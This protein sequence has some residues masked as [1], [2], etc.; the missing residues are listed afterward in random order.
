MTIVT[1]S[2]RET[3][4]QGARMAA[5]A[6]PGDVYA[7]EGELGAGKT[8]FVR[9]FVG[10]LSSGAAVKSPSFSLLDSYSTPA[11]SVHHFDF[12]RLSDPSELTEIGFDDCAGSDSVCLIEWGTLFPDVLPE[13]SYILT[14][15]DLGE[16]RREI[17]LPDGLIDRK[18]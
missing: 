11:F 4:R 7:L 16:N 5:L 13:R 10:A 6:R 1:N 3:R 12:Y 18:E 17:G 8:E 9:G 15:R 14:F 2:V